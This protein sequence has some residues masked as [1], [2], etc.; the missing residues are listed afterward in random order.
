[1]D[2]AYISKERLA[3]TESQS[4]LDVAPELVVE[5]ISPDDRWMDIH[6]KL[7]EYFGSGVQV[8]W[9]VDPKHQ[10]VYVYR[11]LTD[12]TILKPEDT[13]TGGEALPEFCMAVTEIFTTS[14]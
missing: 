8:V 12:I 2:V 13:L 6:D 7:Q 3:Q 14:A 1:M 9:V 5:V 11:S 4:F 10:L